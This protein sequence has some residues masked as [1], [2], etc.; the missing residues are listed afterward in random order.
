MEQYLETINNVKYYAKYKNLTIGDT[1]KITNNRYITIET[2]LINEINE[3]CVNGVSYISLHNAVS[4]FHGLDYEDIRSNESYKEVVQCDNNIIEVGVC[5][6]KNIT[7]LI[8]VDV[9]SPLDSVD[10]QLKLYVNNKNIGVHLTNYDDSDYEYEKDSDDDEDIYSEDSDDDNVNMSCSENDEEDEDGYDHGY[11]EDN[12]VEDVESDNDSTAV[13]EYNGTNI[14]EPIINNSPEEQ[15]N[16]L[17][18]KVLKDEE[19]VFYRY[20]ITEGGE[21]ESSP[22]IYTK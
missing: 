13:M 2:F 8:F 6:I 4:Q 10:K 20:R 12:V 22:V 5:D 18:N 21:F 19:I 1:V 16:I 17:K 14:D 9:E 7:H 3:Q 11:N 15:F